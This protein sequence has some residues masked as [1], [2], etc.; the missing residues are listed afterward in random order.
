[1][2]QTHFTLNT[3]K[4]IT[5]FHPKNKHH[6][7]YDFKT[8]IAANPDLAIVTNIKFDSSKSDSYAIAMPK[9]SGNLKKEIDKVI[10][11]L[12]ADG[13]IEEFVKTNFEL[14]QAA[15]K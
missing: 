15:A 4:T 2:L 8:L 1:M 12:K 13:K 3:T 7:K 11:Q 14:S 6:G 9:D 5:G 10:T